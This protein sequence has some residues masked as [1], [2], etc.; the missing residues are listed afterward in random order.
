MYVVAGLQCAF[1]VCVVFEVKSLL[2]CIVAWLQ[3]HD[4]FKKLRELTD[5]Q[6]R[7]KKLRERLEQTTM[8]HLHKTG[9][10]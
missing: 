10:V 8:D 2:L 9:L 5:Y 6:G 3:F 1:F 7:C 4:K